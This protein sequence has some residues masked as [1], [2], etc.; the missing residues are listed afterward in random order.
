MSL[1]FTARAAARVAL[2]L[3]LSYVKESTFQSWRCRRK[4]RLFCSYP[5]QRVKRLTAAAC[6]W[7][8]FQRSVW[9]NERLLCLV[10]LAFVTVV[11]GSDR[12]KMFYF[13]TGFQ[14]TPITTRRLIR[15]IAENLLEESL[16]WATV[17]QIGRTPEAH[18]Q[19]VRVCLPVRSP[20]PSLA[21]LHIRRHLISAVFSIMLISYK[22]NYQG[23]DHG[24]AVPAI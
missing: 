13:R 4:E 21:H 22:L 2:G 24:N 15:S 16:G 23:G 3:F 1:F 12:Q 5:S 20:L 11:V 14:T 10:A 18:V 7:L 8:L 19:W 17:R 6:K 9:C